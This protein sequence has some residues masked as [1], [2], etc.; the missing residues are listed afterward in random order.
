MRHSK[1]WIESGPDEPVWQIAS[2]V[3]ESRLERLWNFLG[4]A[5]R[6]PASETENVHQL[7][8]FTRRSTAALE[9]FEPWL[10]AKR[11]RKVRKRVG[12][13]R[14]AAGAARDLD[15]LQLRLQSRHDQAAANTIAL[16]LEHVRERRR[17][18]QQPIIELHQH[19]VA[20]DF[21]RKLRKFVKRIGRSRG[22]ADREQRFDELARS[23]LSEMAV[24]YLE[25]AGG[26]MHE[27]EA[28]HAFRIQGKQVRYAMEIFAG[29]FDT[30]FRQDLYPLVAML[31]DRLGTINDHATA[32]ALLTSYREQAASSALREALQAGI[33]DERR[34]LAEARQDFLAWWAPWRRDDLRRRFARYVSLETPG[35][36][37]RV[38][39]E[40]G[41]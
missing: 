15:V 6:E 29:A 31:Q 1:K 41:C 22:S 10:P 13:V 25:A 11:G 4:R 3:L 9:I 12:K 19:L 26:E 20:R 23:K 32:E 40:A 14:R 5:V 30:E 2:R 34:A 39:D 21:D 27:P 7:R 24:P 38:V 35:D 37:Q 36:A 16:L 8:V 17:E 28:L 18:A 33:D